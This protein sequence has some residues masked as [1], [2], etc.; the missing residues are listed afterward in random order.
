MKRIIL[1]VFYKNLEVCANR[2]AIIRQLNPGTKI[3]GLFGG[4]ECNFSAAAETLGQQMEDIYCLRGRSAVWKWLHI[5]LA[6]RHW[7]QEVGRALPFDVLHVIEWDLLPLAPLSAIYS[8]VPEKAVGL[9]ALT[10]IKEIEK[11][12]MWSRL[13]PFRSD[14][15]DLIDWAGKAHAYA[16]EPFASLGPGP[17]LP[18]EFLEQYA[19]AEVPEICHDEIRLPL[20]AQLLGFEVC[21]NGLCESILDPAIWPYFNCSQ[22]EIELPV[23]LDELSKPGARRAFHPYYKNFDLSQIS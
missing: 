4:R 10:P 6:I 2:L 9:T 18:K 3:Y 20:F 12:W 1:F 5:D 13:D 21:Q 22:T 11:Q 8:G 15:A 7:Y 23:I 19:G 17:C 16:A 14:L